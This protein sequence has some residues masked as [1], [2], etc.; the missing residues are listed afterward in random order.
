MKRQISDI[1]DDA[2]QGVLGERA[3]DNALTCET[4][5]C[6]ALIK[7]KKNAPEISDALP[8]IRA[9]FTHI[10]KVYGAKGLS[11]VF[12]PLMF[13]KACKDYAKIDIEWHVDYTDKGKPQLI[14]ITMRLRRP[15]GSSPSYVLQLRFNIQGK[16]TYLHASTTK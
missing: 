15:N 14:V 6:A 16:I 4:A 2:V 11:P 13:A 1:P 9:N 12:D 7:A 5:I 10:I 3:F 8:D